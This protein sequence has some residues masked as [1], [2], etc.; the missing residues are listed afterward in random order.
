MVV[1]PATGLYVGAVA[2]VVP[3]TEQRYH[4]PLS[5]GGLRI[6]D[7]LYA[8]ETVTLGKALIAVAMPDNP[9][10]VPDCVNLGM[11]DVTSNA[12]AIITISF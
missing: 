7:V 12:N 11:L 2:A 5:T 1:L 10:S 9:E 8:V 4:I 6:T 3:A